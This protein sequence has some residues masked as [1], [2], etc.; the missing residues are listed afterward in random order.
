MT[1]IKKLKTELG[2]IFIKYKNDY[3]SLYNHNINDFVKRQNTSYFNAK[4]DEMKSEM[5]IHY[6]KFNIDDKIRTNLAQLVVDGMN[7]SALNSFE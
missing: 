2:K 7:A 6:M 4:S 5:I 3:E 1:E